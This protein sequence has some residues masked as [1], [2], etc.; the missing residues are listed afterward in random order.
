[1]RWTTIFEKEGILGY[2]SSRWHGSTGYHPN[3]GKVTKILKDLRVNPI[4]TVPMGG[5]AVS[6][7]GKPIL[8][9]A[10]FVKLFNLK[11]IKERN[12][13]LRSHVIRSKGRCGSKPPYYLQIGYE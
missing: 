10:Y 8:S 12:N 1:M 4:V 5:A 2:T 6:L 9:S 3:D 11:R 13:F 7:C